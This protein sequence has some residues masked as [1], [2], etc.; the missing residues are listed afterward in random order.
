MIVMI[1]Y[2][3]L[4]WLDDYL[5]VIKKNT[6]GVSAKGKLAWQFL[7]AGIVSYFLI[8]LNIIDTNLYVPFL[9]DQ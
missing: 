7:T 3:L 5:K 6:D 2:F 9:R 1:S 8:H 4:G